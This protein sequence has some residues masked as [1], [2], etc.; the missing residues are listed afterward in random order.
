MTDLIPRSSATN[1]D[2]AVDYGVGWYVELTPA[3]KL[4]WECVAI[5]ARIAELEKGD[6]NG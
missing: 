5:T 2:Y 6:A 1:R 4:F 3:Q